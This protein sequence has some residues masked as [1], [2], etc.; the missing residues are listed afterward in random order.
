MTL[1][2]LIAKYGTH[3]LDVDLCKTDGRIT[4][5]YAYCHQHDVDGQFMVNYYLKVVGRIIPILMEV[6]DANDIWIH[7]ASVKKL[8]TGMYEISVVGGNIQFDV[9]GEL[10]AEELSEQEYGERL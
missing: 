6:E 2:E 9:V 7:L 10:V 4:M 8:G 1:D 3:E 5:V